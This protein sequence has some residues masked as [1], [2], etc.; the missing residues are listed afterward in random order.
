MNTCQKLCEKWHILFGYLHI[1][2]WIPSH[3]CVDT[4]TYLC[5]YL[6]IFEWKPSHICVDTFYSCFPFSCNPYSHHL[7]KLRV[8]LLIKMT[9]NTYNP[10]FHHSFLPC[11]N[12]IVFNIPST[13][14]FCPASSWFSAAWQASPCLPAPLLLLPVI[15][16]CRGMRI[17]S[18]CAEAAAVAAAAAAG[19]AEFAVFAVSKE[20]SVGLV[21]P[22]S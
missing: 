4:F 22:T 14:C 8:F 17:S 3:I 11:F 18:T 15:S 13:F 10:F 2:V 16:L 1:F 21:V 5:G 20:S 9:I 7:N 19:P 12:I 6:H